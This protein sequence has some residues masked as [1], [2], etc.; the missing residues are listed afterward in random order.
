MATA[1]EHQKRETVVQQRLEVRG[2]VS[3]QK[4]GSSVVFG[5]PLFSQAGAPLASPGLCELSGPHFT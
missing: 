1:S 4:F 2:V 5:C 3:D